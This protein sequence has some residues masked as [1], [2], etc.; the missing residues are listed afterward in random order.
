M[1]DIYEKWNEQ[2]IL[3]KKLLSISFLVNAG[4]PIKD[5]CKKEKISLKDF[6]VL[7]RKYGDLANVSEK[8]NLE[9]LF[10]CIDNLI[11]MAE[12][13]QMKKEG[14][15]GY[16][17]KDGKEKF[18]V[19]DV[20]VPVPKNLQ[21]NAYLLEK[22]YGNQWMIDAE[23]LALAAKKANGETWED[24]LDDDPDDPNNGD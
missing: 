9:G 1:S 5:I 24:E 12:G 11:E 21:A 3:R 4:I 19:I 6:Y 14:K 13:Y 20:K 2:G 18:K 16:K 22:S 17:S 23:K 10:F 7:K 15:E 8:G